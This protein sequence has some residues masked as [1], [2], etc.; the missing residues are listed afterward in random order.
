MSRLRL[1]RGVKPL[2]FSRGFTLTELMVV[3]VVVVILATIAIPSYSA[4]I[5]KARRADAV[6]SLLLVQSLQ[7][8]WRTND[9][10]YG[11]LN[12][13][14]FEADTNNSEPTQDEHYTV[15]ITGTP[16]ATAY[17][18]VATAVGDQANDTECAQLAIVVNAA[19]PRGDKRSR[20]SDGDA[21]T[22]CW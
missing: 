21:S 6:D 8:K 13:I 18:V 7:E 22:D 10:D 17:L 3:L 4:M 11:T 9:T 19:N 20:D 12:E 15:S 14:G 5:R 2:L 1:M 16:S